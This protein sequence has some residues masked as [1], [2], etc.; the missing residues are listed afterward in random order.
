SFGTSSSSVT[1]SSS[2][3]MG[4]GFLSMTLIKRQSPAHGQ[5]SG[6]LCQQSEGG[7]AALF[8]LPVANVKAQGRG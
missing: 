1:I 7:M 2:C 3:C 5:A 6:V 8:L 4:V